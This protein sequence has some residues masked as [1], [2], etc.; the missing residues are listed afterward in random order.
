MYNRGEE[1]IETIGLIAK[2]GDSSAL[3]LLRSIIRHLS[4][5]GLKVVVDADLKEHIQERVIFQEVKDFENIDLLMSIGGDGTLLR[6]I[7]EVPKVDKVLLLGINVGTVG[8]LNEVTVAKEG[9]IEELVERLLRGDYLVEE[10]RMLRGEVTEAKKIMFA[11]NEICIIT[12]DHVKIPLFEVFKD[13]ALVER[14]KADGVILATKVGSTAYSGSAMG[15]VIDPG[16]DVILLNH[17]CPLRWGLRPIVFSPESF[18]KVKVSEATCRVL[19]DGKEL[20]AFSPPF[21][22]KVFL[23]DKRVRFVRFSKESFYR[24]LERRMGMLI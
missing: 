17:I 23:S 5:H 22:V 2:I 4:K 3:R 10:C 11:L 7:H 15:P 16:L 12:Q 1:E 19:Y 8:F 18:I 9:D 13:D 20:G 24:R 21:E 14:C 6:A